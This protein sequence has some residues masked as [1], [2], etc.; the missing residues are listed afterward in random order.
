MIN[1]LQSFR[2]FENMLVDAILAARDKNVIQWNVREAN[3]SPYYVRKAL[4]KAISFILDD[5]T[6]VTPI[7]REELR[8]I[9]KGYEFSITDDTV[10][11]KPRH[12]TRGTL[13][14]LSFSKAVTEPKPGEYSKLLEIDGAIEEYV[15]AI[16]LLKNYDQISGEVRLLNLNPE[17]VPSLL[18]K[19]PNLE[20]IPDE[21]HCEPTKHYIVI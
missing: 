16:C 10:I 7:D 11:F 15:E 6:I 12:F 17:W 9:L 1:E 14:G 20:I 18:A 2:R 19:Y 8:T 5:E 3:Y 13:S 4:R 21:I